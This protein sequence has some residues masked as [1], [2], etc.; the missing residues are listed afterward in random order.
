M[1]GNRAFGDRNHKLTD[2][3]LLTA[4]YACLLLAPMTPMLFMGEEFAAS[5]P[6]LYFCDFAPELAKAVASGRRREFS[7]FGAVPDALE[8]PDPN[9]VSTFEASKLHWDER[10]RFPHR[11]RLALLRELIALRR[12]HLTP[13]LPHIAPGGRYQLNDGLLS[14]EWRFDPGGCWRLNVCF[15]AQASV[16]RA[17]VGDVVYSSRAVHVGGQQFRLEPGGV[18]VANSP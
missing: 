9:A 16:S 5:S 14:L 11:E 6:F 7:R 17:E 3:C 18:I 10:E 13:R 1:I 12:Q 2:E 8:V 15:G 4:A